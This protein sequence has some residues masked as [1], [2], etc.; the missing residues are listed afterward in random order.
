MPS[1]PY[2]S[3]EGV[4]EVLGVSSSALAAWLR[5]GRQLGVRFELLSPLLTIETEHLAP[6]GAVGPRSPSRERLVLTPD[7]VEP[8]DVDDPDEHARLDRHWEAVALALAGDDLALPRFRGLSVR[9]VALADTRE[10]VLGWAESVR[11][12]NL[13]A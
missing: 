11:R 6:G 12:R 3:A 10:Q 13:G 4:A 2:L 9:G 8:V 5:L 7:G 1:K